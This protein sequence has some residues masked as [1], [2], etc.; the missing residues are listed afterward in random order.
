METG[1]PSTRVVETGLNYLVANSLQHST[2]TTRHRGIFAMTALAQPTNVT[3]YKCKVCCIW[4][5]IYSRW[6]RVDI[7][8]ECLTEL[9]MSWDIR[10]HLFVI[11]RTI[12]LEPNFAVINSSAECKQKHC[13]QLSLKSM[14]FLV[15]KD[16]Y[17]VVDHIYELFVHLTL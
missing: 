5:Q 7:F 12:D 8:P 9:A 17:S 10:W 13:G 16:Y 14:S 6:S 2:I 3:V 1:H 11:L 15:G 4:K